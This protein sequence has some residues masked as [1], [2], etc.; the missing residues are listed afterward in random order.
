MNDTLPS[1]V[2]FVGSSV[3]PTGVVGSTYTWTFTNVA[4]SSTNV[5]LVTVKVNTVP[6]LTPLPNTVRLAYT[7]QLSQPLTGSQA[8]AN[9][10]VQRP[11]ISVS[12]V[13]SSSNA[14]PGDTVTYT[15]YYNNTGSTNAYNVVVTDTLPRNVT[16]LS[17]SVPPSSISGRT[18]VFNLGTVSTGPHSFTITVQIDLKDRK[19]VV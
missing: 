5:L 10:T 18:Y 4:P 19:S 7:D 3:P 14:Q 11:V 12:K 1:G 16:F 15:I 2:T 6:D 9:V 13:A 17:S 8:W